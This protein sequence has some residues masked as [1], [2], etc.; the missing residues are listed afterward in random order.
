MLLAV[1]ALAF[2]PHVA[3]TTMEPLT[4]QALVERSDL[5]ARVVV[6]SARAERIGRR[7]ITF[8][9]VDIVETWRSRDAA[10]PRTTTVGLP[11][12][13]VDGIGQVVPGT[14]VLE[15][16]KHYVLCLGDD[17]GPHRARMI[18][19]LWLGAFAVVD[20]S[21]LRP[22][23]HAHAPVAGAVGDVDEATLRARFGVRR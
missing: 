16:G 1:V 20:G 7:I 23:T 14:P 19:G 8:Y 21:R 5:V 22:F 18:T 15:V 13:I 12:G 10:P 17:N 11:G 2:A 6:R 9:D 4:D 3:A